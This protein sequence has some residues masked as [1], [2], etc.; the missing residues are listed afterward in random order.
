MSTQ[1]RPLAA[2]A[3]AST[4]SR[5]IDTSARMICVIAWR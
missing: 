4:L 2:P 5:L 3:T 1:V